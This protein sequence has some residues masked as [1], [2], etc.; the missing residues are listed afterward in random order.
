[1]NTVKQLLLM[2][3]L[4][5]SVQATAQ[6]TTGKVEEPE[7]E[8][9]VERPRRVPTDGMDEFT[10]YLGAGRVWSDRTLTPNEEP[11]GQPL[12]NRADETG[13]KTW[14]F[15][16]GVRNRA[17]KFLSYDVGLMIDQFGE[18]Y[19]YEDS[20]SD[21]TMAYTSKYAYYGVPIQVLATYGKDFR[22][23][24]GGGIEPQLLSGY[25]QEREWTTSN[26]SKDDATLKGTEGISQFGFG[27]LASAGFQ[28][29]VG[30]TT[31]IYCIPTWMWN[32]TNTYDDQA[33]YVHKAHSFT[34]KFGLAFH[35]PN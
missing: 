31:S 14:S 16:A 8:P 15:Q 7:K 24:I 10:F 4:L 11:F 29:R 19:L 22:W 20:E 30:R 34:L 25:S 28:W 17:G 3:A 6:I 33:D 5:S 32:L 12:G 18:S 13:L 35:L 1:M 2:G 23:F 27:V 9:K 21:S 26:N